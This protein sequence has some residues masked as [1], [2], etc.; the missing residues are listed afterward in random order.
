MDALA[1]LTAMPAAPMTGAAP[2]IDAAAG[3]SPFAA[4]LAGLVAEAKGVET[5]AEGAQAN[6]PEQGDGEPTE[7]A[8]TM[9]APAA[10]TG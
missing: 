10:A 9:A 5:M 7:A 3:A 6:S 8:A 2:A 1:T 4:L